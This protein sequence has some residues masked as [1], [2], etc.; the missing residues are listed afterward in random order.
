MSTAIRPSLPLRHVLRM[1]C[2][3]LGRD[4]T[5]LLALGL[6][7]VLLAYALWN[8][9]ARLTADVRA[10][11]AV[12][13]QEHDTEH[14]AASQ[15]AAAEQQLAGQT[16]GSVDRYVQHG[17]TH[18]QWVGASWSFRVAALPPPPLSVLAVGRLDVTPT[19]YR[20]R[21]NR[22]IDPFRQGEQTA[23]PLVLA[24]GT[25]DATMVVLV[26]LPL[27][28]IALGAD[29][30]AGDR[31]RGTWMLVRSQPVRLTSVVLVRAAPR[32]VL[33]VAPVVAAG[34]GAWL[35]SA[36]ESR[37]EIAPRIV[38]WTG[39]ALAYVAFWW[40]ATLYGTAARSTTARALVVLMTCWMCAVLIVP[41][42]VRLWLEWQVPVPSRALQIRAEREAK[43]DADERPADDV[44]A[45]FLK[46]EPGLAERYGSIV[47]RAA[48]VDFASGPY[49]LVGE[50]R[51][52]A[53]ERAVLPTLER[54][55]AAKR[56]Q[57]V[58]ARRTSIASPTLLA[59]A[60]LTSA[61][62]TDD[63]AVAAYRRA[64]EQFH[65]TWRTFFLSRLFEVTPLGRADYAALPRFRYEA[66]GVSQVLAGLSW[67]VGALTAAAIVLM[68]AAARR[69]RD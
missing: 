22:L 26:F 3:M 42:T 17:P 18:P 16:I 61:A 9:H 65:H 51:D 19:V 68:A 4:G 35:L 37:A 30:V 54:I 23:H 24:S 7:A 53:T 15:A 20:I 44:L 2:R 47:G 29:L 5:A 12:V 38:A 39:G 10:Y 41:T 33:T 8:A 56:E 36:H 45:A 59:H 13:R 21:T 28:V 58:L 66:P 63:H 46:E 25:L 57:E 32:I 55:A 40:G 60:L 31:E 67:R 48:R 49:Y 62:G 69:L 64:V 11:D 6:F 43:A 1:E 52:Y 50:A 14:E 34:A 27:L